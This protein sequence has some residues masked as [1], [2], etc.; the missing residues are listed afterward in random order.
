MNDLPIRKQ[1]GEEQLRQMRQ[2]YLL[3]GKQVKSYHKAHHMG[4]NTSVPV[5]LAQEL[6]ESVV[7]TLTQAG[8]AERYPDL[9]AALER[10]QEI[11][12]GKHRQAVELLRLVNASQPAWQGEARWETIGALTRYLDGYDPLHLAHR[13]PEQ[14]I[15]PVTLPEELTG[16]D[17]A[18]YILRLLCVENEIMD[19]FPQR[20]VEEFWDI[21]C[22]NDRGFTENQCQRLILNG[23]GKWLL[24]KELSSLVFQCSQREALK[25]RFDGEELALVR[26]ELENAAEEMAAYLGLGERYLLDYVKN[27]IGSWLPYGE[28]ELLF[29]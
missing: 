1:T 5:E 26:L 14:K 9:S 15:Y 25:R 6:M 11:L 4:E 21:F 8:G 20:A 7:Y 10:G 24:C 3:M 29:L 19:A 23:A 22:Q 18:L 13:A 16:I 28:A 12:Q 2:L 17:C 27:A